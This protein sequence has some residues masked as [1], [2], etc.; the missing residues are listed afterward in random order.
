M[1]SGGAGS[2]STVMAS[3]E[4]SIQLAVRF[5]QEVV[6]VR[7]VGVE[8]GL[9]AFDRQLA[10]KTSSLELVQ[11]IVDGRERYVLSET[12]HFGMKLFSP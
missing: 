9:R 3:P 7:G 4:M 8:V 12:R 1:P 2:P 5:E 11:R 6:V 10:Q